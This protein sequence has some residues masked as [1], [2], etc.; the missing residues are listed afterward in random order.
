MIKHDKLHINDEW[1]MQRWAQGVKLVKP[2]AANHPVSLPNIVSNIMSLPVNVYFM[3]IDSCMRKVNDQTAKS[4]GYISTVNAIGKSIRDVSKKETAN[5]IIKNDREIISN[6][7]NKVTTE[8]YTRL[9][10]IDLTAISI[11]FPWYQ[12]D[13]VIGVMGCSILVDQQ[14]ITS[15]SD[16]LS[17]LMQTG[18]LMPSQAVASSLPGLIIDDVYFDER[19]QQIL[20]LTVRGKTAKNIARIISISHRTVE[21]RIE[22]IKLKL[23]VATRSEL[24][25]KVID[26]FLPSRR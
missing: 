9:D 3:D 14:N 21:H 23:S 5:R 15:L 26:Y 12:N 11:K 4:C 6:R 24:I 18:L 22:K 19:D 7:I 20:Y 8:T 10:D 1:E 16:T 13:E 2:T 25:D 17:K